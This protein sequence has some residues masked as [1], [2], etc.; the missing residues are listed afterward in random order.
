MRD[1]SKGRS[2]EQAAGKANLKSRK[3]VANYELLSQLPSEL[4]RPRSYR[5]RHDPF[6]EDWPEVEELLAA[7]P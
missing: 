1:R 7:A 2:Q 5:T 3:T 6:R 4:K